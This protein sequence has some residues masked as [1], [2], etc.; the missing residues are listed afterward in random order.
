[1]KE[2]VP[3]CSIEYARDAGPDRRNYRVDG[4]KIIRA[5]PNFVPQWNARAGAIELYAAY[6]HVGLRLEDFEGAR[7][8]RIDHIKH[9]I[10]RNLL[11]KSLRWRQEELVVIGT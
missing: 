2:I 1:V 6:K 9:L 8:K 10:Q 11:G 7:Y 3:G 4:S 5:L